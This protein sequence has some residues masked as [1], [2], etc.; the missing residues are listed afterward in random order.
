MLVNLICHP[1]LAQ[2]TIAP[3]PAL[4][5]QRSIQ[6]TVLLECDKA[7][8]DRSWELS[9]WHNWS[10]PEQ[11]EANSFELIRPSRIYHFPGISSLGTSFLEFRANLPGNPPSGR[12]LKF[13][14]K[15]RTGPG[16]AWVWA[17][18]A[19]STSDGELIFPASETSDFTGLNDYLSIQ[20]G[21]SAKKVQS[22][23]RDATVWSVQGEAKPAN[24]RTPSVESTLFCTP[25]A[26]SRWM[27]L[28][29]LWSPWLAPRQGKSGDFFLE[30][31]AIFCS[32]LMHDGSHLALLAISGIDDTLTTFRSGENSQVTLSVQNDS[33]EAG[34]TRI[35]IAVGQTFES[36]IAAAMYHARTIVANEEVRSDEFES[37]METVTSNEVNPEW[38]KNWFDGITYCTWNGLGQ[39]LT[40]EKIYTAM[41]SLE[42][43]NVHITNLIIDDNWQSLNNEGQPQ[44]RRGWVEFE[45]NKRG[46]PKGLKHTV[47]QIRTRQPN[48]KHIAVWH[49]LVGYWGA[50]APDGKLA[51]EYKTINVLNKAGLADAEVRTMIAA[52]DIDRF[53]EDFYKFLT[54][55][56]IDS[57]KTDAQFYMDEIYHTDNRRALMKPYQDA[58]AISSFRWFSMKVISCMSQIPQMIFHSQ[59]A[60]GRPRYLLR[61]SDDFYPDVP[62]SHPWHIFCNAHNAL[63]NQH[64]NALPD[65]DMFQTDHPWAG[66]H[67]AARCISGGPIYFTDEPGKHDI[68]LIHQITA[69]TTAGETRILRPN[70][71]GKSI[72]QYVEYKDE[73]L[74]KV[75]SYHGFRD[76]G[77]GMMGLFNV[78]QRELRELVPLSE[79]PGIQKEH[80]YIVRAFS[81]KSV[82]NVFQGGSNE[83]L[84]SIALDMRGWE[85][86]TSFPVHSAGKYTKFA[87]LGLIDKMT[88][89]AAIVN[90]EVDDIPAP[91]LK[92][93]AFSIS[94]TVKALG[95]L[96]I[97]VSNL[98]QKSIKDNF[99]VAVQDLRVPL[100]A[101]G[102]DG[103]HN[104]L[105][106][107][108]SRV[109][110]E[111]DLQGDYDGHLTVKISM[112]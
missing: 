82:T 62:A 57:V 31:G 8:V 48:I 84:T 108:L 44:F 18:E 87:I 47:N 11:W 52:N 27:A 96:G 71:V 105:T 53:Y 59:L 112:K 39:N 75:G 6:F 86:L 42:K 93:N 26:Y 106:I 79:I 61:N 102:I 54:D 25:K 24:G 83:A 58:W 29:R 45:A 101:V 13:T 43:N 98:K 4:R 78:S 51:A 22:Q 16:Q 68:G 40:D 2:S 20:P 21:F 35:V 81:S 15:F 37:E 88:G 91:H 32:F 19:L 10:S 74:L 76:S 85:I 34:V 92:K 30:R 63:L 38:V 9:L 89:A 17:N 7:S 5:S 94:V 109:W 3:P 46:F 69:Q 1:P 36:A 67:A 60:S 12:P 41:D 80:E 100:Q 23:S 73:R 56:G 110:R 55:C 49:A 50:I 14:V 65:W 97:F 99:M 104:I 33:A 66:Y 77:S 111:L 90:S 95:I 70:N 107:D 103:Q 72:Q 28:V 64:L